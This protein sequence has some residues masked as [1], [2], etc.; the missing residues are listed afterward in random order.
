MMMIVLLYYDVASLFQ[1]S[2]GPDR[3]CTPH[4]L[5]DYYLDVL[6]TRQVDLSKSFG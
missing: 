4:H 2:L 5:D 1:V 3:N 6:L